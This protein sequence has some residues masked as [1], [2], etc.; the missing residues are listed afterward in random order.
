MLNLADILPFAGTCGIRR[1]TLEPEQVILRLPDDARVLDETGA[2]H[3]TAVT[4][5]GHVAASSV[6]ALNFDLARVAFQT[7]EVRAHFLR[8]ARSELHCRARLAPAEAERLR[9]V[10]AEQGR[11]DYVMHV[12]V[13]DSE[14]ETVA[15]VE[16]DFA[17]RSRTRGPS[18]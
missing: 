15:E 14:G 6:L 7:R 1:I 2:V 13:L 8:P 5:L 16:L 3:P 10:L 18:T 4:T 9:S 17:F 11:I 12:T